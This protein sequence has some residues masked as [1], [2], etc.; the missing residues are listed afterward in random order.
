MFNIGKMYNFHTSAEAHDACMMKGARLATSKELALA[1][2]AG[3]SWCSYGYLAD[4]D[5]SYPMQDQ[6]AR[7]CDKNAGI[8][9]SHVLDSAGA[10]CFGVKPRYG[11][12]GVYAFSPLR[13]SQYG[14]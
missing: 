13:W 9:T 7:M 12:E 1:H 14:R 3:A 5:P 6:D 2:L 11:T 10:N 4:A 8:V